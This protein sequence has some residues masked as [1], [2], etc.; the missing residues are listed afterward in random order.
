MWIKLDTE[1]TKAREELNTYGDENA[2]TK[3]V[4][5]KVEQKDSLNKSIGFSEE[6][7]EYSFLTQKKTDIEK[8]IK[9]VDEIINELEMLRKWL[10]SDSTKKIL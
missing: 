6:E 1:L 2:I 7:K 4:K 10:V 9:Q 8:N 5:E 3:A